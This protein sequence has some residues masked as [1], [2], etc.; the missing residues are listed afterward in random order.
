MRAEMKR[1]GFFLLLAGSLLVF[2]CATRPAETSKRPP[3]E[4]RE[5]A[6]RKS[7]LLTAEK[8]AEA[9]ARYAV[10][11]SYD[12][13]EER[14]QAVEEFQK[15][16]LA[17]P[18]NEPLVIDVVKR[19]LQQK[20]PEK[21]IEFLS[22]AAG[23]GE[24][25]G[26]VLSWRGIAQAQAGKN[27]DAAESYRQAIRASPTLTLPYHKL[28]EILLAR[29]ST[30]TI[31]VLDQAAALT[32]LVTADLINLGDLYSRS[33]RIFGKTNEALKAKAVDLLDRAVKEAPSNPLLQIKLA[34]ALNLIGEDKK[35]AEIYQKVLQ[36]FPTLPTL[37][38]KLTDLYLRGQDKPRA[39][40]Q[41]EALKRENPT[42]PQV[43]YFLGALAS[44]EQNF[45]EAV[46]H[47]EKAIL[48]KPD[49]EQAYYDLA[50]MQININQPEKA[51]LLLGLARTNFK[52]NFVLEYF[53]GLAYSRLK[54]YSNAVHYF[55][56]A[57]VVAQA[58]EPKRLNQFFYF[59][60]G[61][62][63]ERNQDI[64]QAE[65]YFE[66]CIQFSPDFAEALNYLGY[67]WAEKGV[68]LDRAREL[69]EK[70]VKLDPDNAAYLDSLAWVLFKLKQPQ[71]ALPHLLKAIAGSEEPDATLY[72][73]L[74]DIYADLNEKEKAREAWQKALQ[75]QPDP[76]VQKKL[77]GFTPDP[78]VTK[79]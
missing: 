61:A 9:H 35:A 49:F 79:P 1:P 70:A 50:G 34:D 65:K 15:S 43:Y 8:R 75:I 57:E 36:R 27:D 71:A 17:D 33:S 54:Q 59:Q 21:A 55:T 63:A 41:L 32:N 4:G 20:E 3:Q 74:G 14:E 42:N 11:L 26:A 10:G 37:R 13:R 64:E 78:S 19:W 18:G 16:A 24:A 28:A 38:E 68:K 31:Q 47:Y 25:S 53:T 2:G 56:A 66:K 67:M 45:P 5:D 58:S 62:S 76:A 22:K 72:D 48:L 40:E 6:A 69:I 46:E 73:H 39:R 51:L 30:E 29:E 60:A 44:E 7:E 12:F 23:T 77:Q 52:R